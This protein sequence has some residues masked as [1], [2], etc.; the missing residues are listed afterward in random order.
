MT[1]REM[2]ESKFKRGAT[3]FLW[4]GEFPVLDRTKAHATLV[5][6]ETPPIPGQDDNAGEGTTE[7]HGA[8]QR[9]GASLRKLRSDVRLFSR[10]CCR[11]RRTRADD[12]TDDVQAVL[13]RQAV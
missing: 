6:L 2:W 1:P 9:R 13:A 7:V 11:P 3:I 10:S 4:D 12:K 8:A 5:P